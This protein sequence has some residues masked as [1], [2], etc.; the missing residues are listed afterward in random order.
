MARISPQMLPENNKQSPAV[1]KRFLIPTKIPSE[2]T[3]SG[4]PARK[5]KNANTDKHYQK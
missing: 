3:K 5:R 4:H 2:I 1:W